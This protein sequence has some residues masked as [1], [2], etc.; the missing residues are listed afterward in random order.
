MQINSDPK[1]TQYG[2]HLRNQGTAHHSAYIHFWQYWD[3]LSILITILIFFFFFTMVYFLV[4][5]SLNPLGGGILQWQRKSYFLSKTFQIHTLK[6]WNDTAGPLILIELFMK[7][8]IFREMGDPP[9]LPSIPCCQK[10]PLQL[11]GLSPDPLIYYHSFCL[12]IKS[13]T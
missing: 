8:S 7:C 11:H 4:P 6:I 3:C 1:S 13:S 12:W 2:L 10:K 9:L 5:T